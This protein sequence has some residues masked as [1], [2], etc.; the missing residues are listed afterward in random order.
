MNE[1]V[2]AGAP[3]VVTYVRVS[4]EHQRYSL[5]HQ[6]IA[7]TDYA[8]QNGYNIIQEYVDSGKSGLSIRGRSSLAQLLHDVT[9]PT[10]HFSIIVVFDVSRW[11][12]FQ[13][14]DQHAAYEFICR[15]V[16]VRIEYTN[17]V[18]A[19]DTSVATSILKH[20]KR[21]MAAEFSRDL[22]QKVA[23][24]QSHRASQGFKQGGLITY[25]FRRLIVSADGKPKA[26]LHI[27]E[28]KTLQ[29][30]RVLIVPGPP[31]EIQVVRRIF[32]L[33]VEERNSMVTI[34]RT[35]NLDGVPTGTGFP[36]TSEK[37]RGILTSTLCVGVY[38][39][40]KTR[41]RL[42]E[43]QTKNPTGLWVRA[44]VGKPLIRETLFDEAQKI[45]GCKRPH[46]EY[47]PKKMLAGLRKL[48]KQKGH[49]SSH[50]INT[51]REIP[52]ANTYARQFGGLAGAY[53]SVGYKPTL[54][55]QLLW[56]GSQQRCL[57]RY[58]R[59]ALLDGLRRLLAEKGEL[60]ASIV[61]Q[62][63]YTASP[64]TYFRRFGSMQKAYA[65]IGYTRP[66]S[67][68]GNGWRRRLNV[69][70]A[71]RGLKSLYDQHGFITYAMVNQEPAIP[72]ATWYREVFGS[73]S[74]ACAEADINVS[75]HEKIT[76][77]RFR[78]MNQYVAGDSAAN[79][80][81]R[82][83]HFDITDAELMEGVRRLFETHGY[84]NGRMIDD[85]LSLP[86][87]KTI[88]RRYA[89]LKHL[90]ARAGLKGKVSRGRAI[91]TSSNRI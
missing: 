44:T 13:D 75:V 37:V 64:G 74:N 78:I 18:F 32:K 88:Y 38:S 9:S 50:I 46:N 25:G 68:P 53:A 1:L 47:S 56:Y 22:S 58:G 84:I 72:S 62:C 3:N 4:T 8:R 2:P 27:G 61:Q 29:S 69:D 48:L 82:Q 30:D 57:M 15:E 12:R 45:L 70:E 90:Y 33:F 79:T 67:P 87:V 5:E 63:E 36:W 35:L 71:I 66:I 34:A 60:S 26:L 39:Y 23:A 65:E 14:V 51:C 6:R 77:S 52:S 20:I 54:R 24:A 76:E 80:P 21:V 91:A 31:E 55:G 10:R 89:S 16:G 85:D 73:F 19:N 42:D 43:K 28:L 17:E 83:S 49:L 81:K 41:R 59:E 40:N 11:G 86:A 7:I